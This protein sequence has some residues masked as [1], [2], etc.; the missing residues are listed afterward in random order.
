[1]P[2]CSHSHS[3]THVHSDQ[4]CQ[5][6]AHCNHDVRWRGP[7]GLPLPALATAL[8][9][10]ALATALFATAVTTLAAATLVPVAGPAPA[11]PDPIAAAV[12]TAVTATTLFATAAAPCPT[13]AALTSTARTAAAISRRP[14]PRVMDVRCGLG[15]EL[16]PPRAMPTARVA[17]CGQAAAAAARAV[18]RR[19][20]GR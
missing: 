4:P 8:T 20:N 11:Q 18:P 17:A 19:A 16:L 12:S 5:R 3:R 9:T 6:A 14:S 13:I 1:M 15:R 7:F 2:T 10:T